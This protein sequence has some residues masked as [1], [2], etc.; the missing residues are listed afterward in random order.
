MSYT[1][2][3]IVAM[4]FFASAINYAD[5]G[6]LGMVNKSLSHDLGL[7]P[8]RMGYLITAW[9]WTYVAAQIPCGWLL[10]RFGSKRV[11][12][13]AFF[14]WSFF[15]CLMGF[16]KF[17]NGT[18]AYVVL[19]ALIFLTGFSFAPTFP[20]NGRF[21]AAWFPTSERGTASAIF[22]SS[23][24][25]WLVIFAPPMGWIIDKC[26]WQYVFWIMGALGILLT[27]LW[28]KFVFSPKEHPHVNAAELQYIEQGGALVNMDLGAKT[29]ARFS[30][31]WSHVRQLLGS[32][33]LIGIYLGQFCITTLTYFF[34]Q[35]FPD[36]LESR[37]LSIAKAGF[38]AVLPALCGCVGG[39]L[40]GVFSDFLLRCGFSLTF[41][42]KL[43]IVLGM[44]LACVMIVCNYVSAIRLVIAVMCLSFFGKGMG[45]L[46]WTVVSDTSPKEITGLSG[47]LFNTFGNTAALTTG[48]TIGY[49]VAW[50]HSYAAALVYIG[51]NAIGAIFCYLVVVGEIKRLELKS[52]S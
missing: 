19:F 23:Q 20:G 7:N 49:L 32:R 11:Y 43:P 39:V 17:L 36:Y 8:A 48:I 28:F 46:G 18:A 34:V 3:F 26:G 5:R 44:L 22:N 4:L 50:T 40:G 21:V 27:P 31:K 38:A 37:G 12:G 9:A 51:A 16:T 30:V 42:R 2:Y 45:A 25:V 33:M 47:G 35:W 13:I 1:R 29:G 41:A 15:V 6:I 10:D 52:G 24:Y 14:L